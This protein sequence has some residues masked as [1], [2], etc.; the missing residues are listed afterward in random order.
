M[1]VV[2]AAVTHF[3]HRSALD[4][5]TV[6]LVVLWAVAL[7]GCFLRLHSLRKA[8]SRVEMRC[9]QPESVPAD[10]P[11][12]DLTAESDPLDRV[13]FVETFAAA[14]QKTDPSSCHVFGLVGSWGSGKT[15]VL[16]ALA[17]RLET[18]FWVIRIPS[19]A[20]RETGRLTEVIL[21]SL[22]EEIQNRYLMPDLRRILRRYLSVISPV[23]KQSGV[24]EALTRALAD[25]NELDCLKKRL[26]EAVS[27][28][29]E[30]YLVLIDDADRL[31]HGELQDLFRAVRLCASL[32][33]VVY[34]IAYDRRQLCGIVERAGTAA[35]S[36]FI[37]KI[38]E[39]EW[40]LP[41][42]ECESHLRFIREH[43]PGADHAPHK[44]FSEDFDERFKQCSWAIRELLGTPRHVKRVEIALTHRSQIVSRLN[45]FD[46]FAWEIVRQRAPEVYDLIRRAPWLV[47]PE[48]WSETDWMHK[49]FFE[50][51]YQERNERRI[52]DAIDRSEHPEAVRELFWNLFPRSE[53]GRETTRIFRLRR[54]C[55]ETF[56]GSY[57]LGEASQTQKTCDGIEQ[58][59]KRVNEAKDHQATVELVKRE[60]D[61]VVNAASV[62]EWIRVLGQFTDDIKDPKVRAVIEGLRD[63][64]A[65]ALNWASANVANVVRN[66]VRL[67]IE[68]VSRLPSDQEATSVLEELLTKT[69]TLPIAGMY[70]YYILHEKDAF[71][72]RRPDFEQCSARFDERIETELNSLGEA[73]F[74]QPR[75]WFATMVLRHSK[76]DKVYEFIE[77]AA[78]NNPR[79]WVQFLSIF[80]LWW[81][82]GTREMDS[83]L[84]REAKVPD[85]FLSQAYTSLRNADMTAWTDHEKAAARV[86][87]DAWKSSKEANPPLSNA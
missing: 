35:A 64:S 43:V 30:R 63:G 81:S 16:N 6:P 23:A 59:T 15:S 86:F 40:P 77:K 79:R 61:R 8:L 47:R 53:F 20:F 9:A 13:A 48:S 4:S 28:A 41:L 36:E 68:L 27:S 74:D 78:A 33:R 49:F 42:I 60:I 58:F 85:K 51:E 69:T 71:L 25:S 84:I 82:D 24:L 19:W 73:V 26:E 37:D 57:F 62:D 67:N 14:I 29:P 32:P 55:H 87:L 72:P 39:A 2:L 65:S 76:P 44:R 52:N 17:K 31:G 5:G 70:A 75:E 80:V 45:R 7:L 12:P 10:E 38:V 66:L 21:Q 54:I 46:V 1:E 11:L 3:V 22:I 34:V 83:D 50:K 56:F 18:K